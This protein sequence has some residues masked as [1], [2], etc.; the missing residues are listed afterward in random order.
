VVQKCTTVYR[1][2]H[3]DV[4]TPKSSTLTTMVGLIVVLNFTYK[5]IYNRLC[6]QYIKKCIM[7]EFFYQTT[8]MI[9]TFVKTTCCALSP[10]IKIFLILFQ[11]CIPFLTHSLYF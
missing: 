6:K 1:F 9:V 11:K 8:T 5:V 10:Q 7:Y 2:N 4:F 3:F